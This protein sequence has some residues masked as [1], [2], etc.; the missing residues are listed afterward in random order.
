MSTRKFLSVVVFSFLIGTFVLLMAGNVGWSAAMLVVLTVGGAT[1]LL[2][3]GIWLW[4][5]G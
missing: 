4:V 1:G 3:L 2:I 5:T